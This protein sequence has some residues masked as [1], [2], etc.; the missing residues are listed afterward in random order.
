MEQHTEDPKKEKVYSTWGSEFVLVEF[1][2]KY[3]K[4]NKEWGVKE[5]TSQRR[6]KQR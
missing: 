5:V 2:L 4:C 6:Q 1:K 3:D